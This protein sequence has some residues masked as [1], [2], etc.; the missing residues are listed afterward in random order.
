[1][2]GF[3]ALIVKK[4]IQ[5]ELAF[6]KI[7]FLDLANFTIDNR[8]LISLLILLPLTTLLLVNTF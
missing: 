4:S 3:L 6:A 5:K 7:G 8:F 2:K 1:M